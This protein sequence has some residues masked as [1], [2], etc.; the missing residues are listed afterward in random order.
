[1]VLRPVNSHVDARAP[2]GAE[3]TGRGGAVSLKSNDLIR[4]IRVIMT[5]CESELQ[6]GSE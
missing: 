1:V 6:G 2:D 4:V 3:A 5:V